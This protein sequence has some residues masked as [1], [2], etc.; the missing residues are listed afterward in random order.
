LLQPP[1]DIRKL[2]LGVPAELDHDSSTLG[3]RIYK[4]EQPLEPQQTTT[5]EFDLFY[6]KKGFAH[7]VKTDVVSNGT[8]INSSTM[9]SFGYDAGREISLERTRKK[10]GFE[11]KPRMRDL[12]DEQGRLHNYISRDAHWVTYEA[13]VST[14][15]DQVAL[16]PGYLQREWVEDGRRYFHYAMDAPILHFVSFLSAKYDVVSDNWND[17]VA[18]EVYHHAKHDWNVTRMIDGVKR[19]LDYFSAEFS[20]YQHRQ[21]RILEFP[22]YASFAQSFPNTIPYSESIGFIARVGEDDIDYPFYVTA[23]EVAHQ[24]WAH[25]VIG[26]E[27]QGATVLS[28]TLS[29]YSALMVMEREY[30]VEKMRRFLRYELDTYLQGRTT[31]RDK[32][33]PLLRVENQGYIHYRKGSVI[34]Y[35]LKDVV[36]EQNLNRALAGFID[37]WGF[38]G[39]PYPTS[40]DLLTA[41]LDVTPDE[42]KNW[43]RQMF[44]EI[45]LYEN[46]AESAVAKSLG[47]GRYEV[48]LTFDARKLQ[49]GEQGEESEVALND[50][51]DIGVFGVDDEPLYFERH[52]LDDSATE[53]TVTV[54]GKPV[55]AGIDPYHKLID[56]HPEDNETD[57]EIDEG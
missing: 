23:H 53:I 14:A 42:Y 13:V 6:D 9:P 33:L 38:K 15:E 19:S 44:E 50:P 11:A 52:Q 4:L 36:G 1:V 21:V 28:E 7:S 2:E 54:D 34:M 51:I 43:V 16:S 49:A 22:R 29:Q 46:K 18:I 27:V 20:P 37:D 40:R 26:G 57:V 24:W 5:L 12:D 39:P 25:Q 55:S 17:E 47:G 45:I 41:F 56:R 8:F 10:H 30:G 48:T 35:A 3:Y 31:E 32:E